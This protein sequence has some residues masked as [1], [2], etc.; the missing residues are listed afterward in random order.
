[1]GQYVPISLSFPPQ[2]KIH[3]RTLSWL[4]AS[5]ADL[6]LPIIELKDNIVRYCFFSEMRV[7]QG[8]LPQRE[9]QVLTLLVALQGRL[10]EWILSTL[11]R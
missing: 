6:L 2:E 8:V 1:M 5:T 9:S 3:R 11:K 7:Y 10:S 4:L